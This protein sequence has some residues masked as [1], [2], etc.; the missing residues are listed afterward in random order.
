MLTE[1]I[2]R[3]KLSNLITVIG[4]ACGNK[5]ELAP[6]VLNTT[7]GHSIRGIGLRPRRARFRNGF[8]W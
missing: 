8:R 3:N 4:A 7:M 6:L 2:G 1:N 5:N